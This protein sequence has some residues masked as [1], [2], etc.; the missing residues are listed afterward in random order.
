M[1]FIRWIRQAVLLAFNHFL[2]QLL[3]L[4]TFACPSIALRECA[5]HTVLVKHVMIIN[6]TSM[7]R[8]M[9]A[10]IQTVL[11]YVGL[12]VDFRDIFILSCN[13]TVKIMKIFC[14]HAINTSVH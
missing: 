11:Q 4:D 10:L 1:R 5:I 7:A 2:L 9:L 14:H 6:C 13:S 12:S 8:L 3:D